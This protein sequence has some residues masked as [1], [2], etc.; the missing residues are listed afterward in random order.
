[1][2]RNAWV[3][4]GSS[5]LASVAC[6][7]PTLPSDSPVAIQ[8]ATDQVSYNAGA[9]ATVRLDNQT[10]F[11]H[12]VAVACHA[13]FERRVGGDWVATRGSAPGCTGP[14]LGLPPNGHV[15]IAYAL[16]SHL[17]SGE[18]RLRFDIVD[19]GVD[20]SSTLTRRSNLFTLLP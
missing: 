15:D 11:G 13:A 2:T 12:Y 18:Y 1:M 7:L 10:D 14:D 16:D 17:P 9:T 5:A 19:M 20:R 3:V 6:G 8:I 4:I